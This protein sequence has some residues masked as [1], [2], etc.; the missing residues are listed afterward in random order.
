MT[1]F[2]E[3]AD[4][5]EFVGARTP[6]DD[7]DKPI[8]YTPL[9]ESELKTVKTF[10]D[11]EESLADLLNDILHLSEGDRRLC[12]D[13]EGNNLCRLATIA[14]L[15]IYI[16]TIHKTC[17]FDGQRTVEVSATDNAA[18]LKDIFEDVKYSKILFDLRN[19]SDALFGL[20]GVRLRGVE[21]V[22]LMACHKHGAGYLP[23]LAKCIKSDATPGRRHQERLGTDEAIRQDPIPGQRLLAVFR[24]RWTSGCRNTASTTSAGCFG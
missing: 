13:L 6:Y 17:L 15:Q 11:S 1:V 23:G 21:D 7:E 9:S 18:T 5:E 20:Y 8:T 22:Q 14:I 2:G 16:P 12:I 19:D 3:D 4:W 24:A 10:V